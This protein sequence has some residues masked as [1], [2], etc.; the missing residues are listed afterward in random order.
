MSAFLGKGLFVLLDEGTQVGAGQ[1]ASRLKHQIARVLIW[2]HAHHHAFGRFDAGR[3]M[4][5]VTAS[6]LGCLQNIARGCWLEQALGD[7]QLA[8]LGL[9]RRKGSAQGQRA[10]LERH[11]P[12]AAEGEHGGDVERRLRDEKLLQHLLGGAGVLST[13]LTRHSAQ[14]AHAAA[15]AQRRCILGVA[16]HLGI[17]GFRHQK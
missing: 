17:V 3:Q 2:I 1:V 12:S 16:H 11:A 15:Q 9:A 14:W 4:N 13:W 5:A 7:R 6:L 10:G 8:G